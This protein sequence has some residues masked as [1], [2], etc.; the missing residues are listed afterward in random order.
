MNL[1]V[2]KLDP[3]LIAISKEIY[4]VFQ[5]SYAVEAELLKAVDFPPLKR[6][7]EKFVQSNND[8]FGIWKN[9]RLAAVAEISCT[10]S[11]THIQS[12]VVHPIYFRKGLATKIMD[13]ILVQFGENTVMVETGLDNLPAIRLYEKYGF[14]EVSR[15]DTHHGIKKVR[16]ELSTLK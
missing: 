6:T 12:L 5:A 13:F 15:F 1:I 11:Q 7:L 3:Q 9:D 14:K 16:F 4:S 10:E 2:Q 8:F